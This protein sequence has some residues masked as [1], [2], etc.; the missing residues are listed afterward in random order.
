MHKNLC[1]CSFRRIDDEHRLVDQ[2]ERS[3][4][5]ILACHAPVR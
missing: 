2:P 5:V 1:G 3:L 4:L